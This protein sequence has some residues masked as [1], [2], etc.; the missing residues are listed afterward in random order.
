[1][2]KTL[3]RV[4]A[5]GVLAMTLSVGCASETASTPLTVQN[6]WVYTTEDGSRG[7]GLNIKADN[8]YAVVKVAVKSSNA[9]S[10]DTQTEAGT[11][12]IEANRM[13]FTP[14][15][16]TC[17]EKTY[18]P[19]TGIFQ[20]NADSLSVAFSYGTIL[21]KLN[22]TAAGSGA[23]SGLVLTNGCFVG[24]GAFV[25][26]P[27]TPIGSC[28]VGGESCS[29][30]DATCCIGFGCSPSGGGICST[31]CTADSECKSGCCPTAPTSGGVRVCG[32]TTA[33]N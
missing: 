17:Q 15:Q 6:S 5:A 2:T 12:A 33:C 32:P 3:G 14:E 25:R 29:A 22:T 13:T 27:L 7:T 1:M 9:N 31:I 4:L 23:S 20:L 19:Y 16:W 18:A 24:G 28:G 11:V 10:L 21:F 8:T 26:S 30:P